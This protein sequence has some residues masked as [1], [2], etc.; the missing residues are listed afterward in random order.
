MIRYYIL[1]E[2]NEKSMCWVS[3]R[4]FFEFDY[5]LKWL[6]IMKNKYPSIRY[7]LVGVI[8]A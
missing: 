8:D 7:R 5:A 2:F 6:E 3:S 4:D 1:E